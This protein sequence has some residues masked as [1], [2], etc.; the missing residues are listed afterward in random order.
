MRRAKSMPVAEAAETRR[1]GVT[2][3]VTMRLESLLMRD[4]QSPMASYST[5]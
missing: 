2:Q 3:V 4:K 1:F 5:W